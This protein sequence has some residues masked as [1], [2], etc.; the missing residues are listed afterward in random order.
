[1]VRLGI[2]VSL[3]VYLRFDRVESKL[4]SAHD[5]PNDSER[6]LAKPNGS[7]LMDKRARRSLGRR[8]MA[9]V[10]QLEARQLMA[11]S[12][13][14]GPIATS[15]L[16]QRGSNDRTGLDETETQLTPANVNS[17]RNSASCLR[18]RWTARCGRSRWSSL[19]SRSVAA[20]DLGV[21]TTSCTS[22]PKMTASMPLIRPRGRF[23]GKTVSSI[24]RPRASPRCIVAKWLSNEINPEYGITSTPV[25]D[26]TTNTL[27]LIADTKE[28]RERPG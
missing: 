9:T 27:Y 22:P 19:T 16:T 20:A 21:H 4:N 11:S 17:A 28:V 14:A 5:G 18:H 2:T 25:I 10:E 6:I 24:P 7:T 12:V 15:I 13:V 23:S 8:S 1:M 3:H 26:P